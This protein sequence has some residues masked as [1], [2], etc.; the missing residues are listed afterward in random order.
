MAWLQQS[1]AGAIALLLTLSCA[2]VPMAM[3]YHF[4]GR[5]D[6]RVL[7][8]RGE[9]IALACAVLAGLSLYILTRPSVVIL[10]DYACRGS[11]NPALC[12][13]GAD[14]PDDNE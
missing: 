1:T 5:R 11:S 4:T 3:L 13:G 2:A 14:A 9:A 6:R 8:R 12:R 7:T 10:H